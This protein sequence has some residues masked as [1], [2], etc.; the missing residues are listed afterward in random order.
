MPSV[1]LAGT[2]PSGHPPGLPKLFIDR[3]LG[4]IRLPALLRAAGLEV[5]TLAEH[6]GMPE[7]EGVEDHVW[8]RDTAAMGWIALGKDSR[9]R[10]NPA[11]RQAIRS[12]GA[13]CFYIPRA[14][15]SFDEN[16]KRVLGNLPAIS[17]ACIDPGPFV[18]ALHP[19][20]IKRM[21]LVGGTFSGEAD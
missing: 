1:S 7:D 21:R 19:T 6:Y 18:Y 9:I 16:C 3:S 5:I 10:R 15:L 8:L 20:R 17:R 2:A 4:R 14:D 13:R 12:A 11:E